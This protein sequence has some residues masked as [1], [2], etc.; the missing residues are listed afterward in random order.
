MER[1]SCVSYEISLEELLSEK[2]NVYKSVNTI[3]II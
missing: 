2:F 1:V 3:G